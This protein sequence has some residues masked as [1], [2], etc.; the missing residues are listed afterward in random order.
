MK[1]KGD[2]RRV[3]A[4]LS[5]G[6]HAVADSAPAAKDAV[7]AGATPLSESY[8]QQSGWIR[9][10]AGGC[11]TGHRS[12]RSPTS[13]ASPASSDLTR[14]TTLVPVEGPAWSV[15]FRVV[16]SR[17]RSERRQLVTR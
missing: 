12:G 3:L 8:L 15:G 10:Q 2:L 16:W 9:V 4:D 1:R 6:G 17:Y 7:R 13:C 11:R 5:H 14:P